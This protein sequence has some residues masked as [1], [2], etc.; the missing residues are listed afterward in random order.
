MFPTLCDLTGLPKPDFLDGT[1]LVPILEDPRA[2][3]HSA[4]SYKGNVRTIRTEA[5]RLVAHDGGHL[6]LLRSSPARRRNPEPC[7]LRS[8]HGE[9]TSY[10][11]PRT[12]SLTSCSICYRRGCGPGG[13]E[14]IIS[15]LESPKV[16]PA[17][18]THEHAHGGPLRV[19]RDSVPDLWRVLQMDR[20]ARVLPFS[21]RKHGGWR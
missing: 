18:P 2:P 19:A 5:Y 14:G 20:S 11:A 6:E 12:T 15:Q 9:G 8:R 13:P 3:G 4:C 16:D 10:A 21:P 17:D 1:S 7:G